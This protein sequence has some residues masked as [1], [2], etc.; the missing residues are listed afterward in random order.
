MNLTDYWD[1]VKGFEDSKG[2]ISI[3]K[4]KKDRQDNGQKKMYKR[5]INYLQNMHIKLKI[6]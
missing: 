1:V 4:S 2:V 3:R 6:E 5:T